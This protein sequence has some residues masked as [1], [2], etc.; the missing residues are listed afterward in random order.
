MSLMNIGANWRQFR[1]SGV[2]VQGSKFC[3]LCDDLKITTKATTHIGF[4]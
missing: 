3:S 4:S 2:S 1:W